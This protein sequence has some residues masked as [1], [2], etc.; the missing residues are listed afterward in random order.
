MKKYLNILLAALILT[1]CAHEQGQESPENSDYDFEPGHEMMVLGEK[2]QDPYSVTN[3]TKAIQNLYPTKGDRVDVSP[4]DLYVRFLPSCQDQYDILESLGVVLIDHPVD[5]RIIKDG[6]YY[7]D[8]SL[9]QEGFT[10]QYAVVSPDFPFPEGIEY[11]ILDECYIA[12]NDNAS[13]AEMDDIDWQAVEREAFRITGNA[14]MFEAMTKAGGK[15]SGRI[16]IK[17]PDA[18]GGKAFGVA[19]VHLACNV[20]VKVATTY[21]DRDGYYTMSQTFYSKP[22]YWINFKNKSGFCIGLNLVVSQGSVS[23]LGKGSTEGINYEITSSSDA[24]LYRR[25]VVNNAAYDYFSRCNEDDMNINKPSDSIVIWLL[26]V[27]NMSVTPMFHHGTLLSNEYIDKYFGDW[28]YVIQL[29]LPDIVLGLKE[30]KSYADIYDATV[31]ELSHA[32][33]FINVGTSYWNKYIL[34]VIQSF[35]NASATDYGD[36]TLKDAQTCGITEMWAYF[37]Q[38]LMHMER[39]GGPFPNFGSGYWFHPQIFKY[40]EERGL[41]RDNIFNALTT[42][43]QTFDELKSKL[44]HMYPAYKDDIELAFNR[45]GL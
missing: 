16:T 42:D 45:Y 35:I 39:Y 19:G 27:F 11:E 1:A 13:K 28:K 32:S 43:V 20:F 3:V 25:A 36:G 10:W 18:N 17:D 38:N 37:N 2:L 9:P 40:M 26:D 14:Q 44:Y 41:G 6:D 31:H 12:E 4:T 22:R 7:H 8:P 23:T 33:H 21:T 15:P 30:C 29:F 24:K 34:Y 5:H